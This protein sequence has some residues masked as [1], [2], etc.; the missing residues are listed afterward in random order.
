MYIMYIVDCDIHHD[1][2]LRLVVETKA[3]LVARSLGTPGAVNLRPF[4]GVDLNL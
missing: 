2:S 1:V 4:V 3:S